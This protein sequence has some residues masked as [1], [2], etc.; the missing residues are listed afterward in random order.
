[1]H[2]ELRSTRSA[3]RSVAVA[4]MLQLAA[5]ATLSIDGVPLTCDPGLREEECL[6]RAETGLTSLT[7]GHPPPSA[8]HVTCEATRCDADGGAGVVTVQF[9]DGTNETVDIGFGRT[10]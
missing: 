5:C 1:M 10:N 9:S 3:A 7:P 6:A 8:V 4:L 2:W